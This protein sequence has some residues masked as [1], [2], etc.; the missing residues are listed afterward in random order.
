[1]NAALVLG[2]KTAKGP[3]VFFLHGLGDSGEGVVPVAK[4]FVDRYEDQT[5]VLPTAPSRPV[6]I[7]GGAAMNAWF[8]IPALQHRDPEA[9]TGFEE[10][11]KN[12]TDLVKEH[13]TYGRSVFLGGFSQGGVIA[14]DVGYSG[15]IKGLAGVFGLSTYAVRG[16]RSKD[17]DLPP[18]LM[19]H[20]TDD[21]VVPL[22][23]GQTSFNLLKV[24][25]CVF[26]CFF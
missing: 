2:S 10:S 4:F 15:N 8:D 23:W 26:F 24:C 17:K 21:G 6:T 19:L 5:W 13:S 9:L 18:L 22:T 1:M 12:V 11:V 7:N 25:L 20:G 14:L 16:A 3:L